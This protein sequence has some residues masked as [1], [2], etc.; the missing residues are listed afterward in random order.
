MQGVAMRFLLAMGLALVLA[1]VPATPPG[2][3]AEQLETKVLSVPKP[4]SQFG[5]EDHHGRPFAKDRL[6]GRWSLMMLGFTHCPDVCPFTLGNLALVL[7]ELSTRVSPE[8]LPQVVFVAVDPARDKAVLADYVKHFNDGFIG[9]TGSPEAI[10]TLVDSLE[11]YVR[12]VRKQADSTSYQ[13]SHSANVSVVDPQG[14]IRATL[15]PPMEP[16]PAA[17]FLTGLMRRGATE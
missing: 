5:L 3:W 10:K 8:R 2:V 16:V 13:V 4:L 6:E 11:G 1:G 14:R 15:N 17:E 7:E 12:V 9:I